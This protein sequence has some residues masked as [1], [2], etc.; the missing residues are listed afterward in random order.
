MTG[1]ESREVTRNELLRVEPLRE[2]YAVEWRDAAG[3]DA[4][5]LPAT[6]AILSGA[7]IRRQGWRRCCATKARRPSW[8]RR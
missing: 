4:A 5:A 7:G 2:G 3:G 1:L 8:W 6:I